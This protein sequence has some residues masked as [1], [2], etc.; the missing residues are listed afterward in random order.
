MELRNGG[1]NEDSFYSLDQ[2]KP[3]VGFSYF[4][5][6]YN[7]ITPKNVLQKTISDQQ[8]LFFYVIL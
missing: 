3:E 5:M 6:F 1:R 8:T 4:Q 2:T 7:L